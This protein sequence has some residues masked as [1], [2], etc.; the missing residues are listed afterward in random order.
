MPTSLETAPTEY[1]VASGIQF[2]YRRLGLHTGTPLILL[3]HFTGNMDSWD[4]AVVNNLAAR[5]PV[6]V[7]DNT[8]VGKSGGKTPDNVAQMATDAEHFLAASARCEPTSVHGALFQYSKLFV[9]HVALF[10][11]A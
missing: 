8:G 9:E 5:R 6:I 2:A 3:Q 1:I 4:P 11:N 10:L 7:F